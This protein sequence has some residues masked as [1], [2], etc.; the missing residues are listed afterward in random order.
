LFLFSGIVQ[1]LDLLFRLEEL[2]QVLEQQEQALVEGNNLYQTMLT[3]HHDNSLKVTELG[4]KE[5]EC[6]ARRNE[7]NKEQ[8]K[9][10]QEVICATDNQFLR[11]R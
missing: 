3:T 5:M 6:K 11:S 9:L 8:V 10:Q 4:T 1:R 7:V 2:Q